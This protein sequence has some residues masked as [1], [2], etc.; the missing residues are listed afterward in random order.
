M[1]KTNKLLCHWSLVGLVPEEHILER[2]IVLSLTEDESRELMIF[3]CRNDSS[4]WEVRIYK[5][6]VTDKY[7]PNILDKNIKKH[8]ENDEYA[9]FIFD[10][11]AFALR[12]LAF[13]GYAHPEYRIRPPTKNHK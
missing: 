6:N 8:E 7:V 12:F 5:A 1:Q 2:N 3:L 13:V 11:Y 10:D 9:T 4:E